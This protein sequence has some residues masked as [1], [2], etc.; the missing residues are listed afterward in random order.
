[1]PDNRNKSKPANEKLTLPQKADPRLSQ[2][3]TF[4]YFTISTIHTTSAMISTSAYVK[5]LSSAIFY[6]LIGICLATII[7]RIPRELT[8]KFRWW[9]RSVKESDRKS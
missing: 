2:K 9:A 8:L 3:C 5:Y 1:M 7:W 4:L 6:F